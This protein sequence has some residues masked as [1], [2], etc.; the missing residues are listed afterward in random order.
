MFV[1][2]REIDLPLVICPIDQISLLITIK[3]ECFGY[4]YPCRPNSTRGTIIIRLCEVNGDAGWFHTTRT[5]AWVDR[6]I[7]NISRP[8]LSRRYQNAFGRFRTVGI[9]QIGAMIIANKPHTSLTQCSSSISF[10][11]RAVCNFWKIPLNAGPII[12]KN[13]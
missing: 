5:I 6:R 2:G 3:I 4:L 13:I 10:D 8:S 12:I 1:N 9:T 7:R 11:L